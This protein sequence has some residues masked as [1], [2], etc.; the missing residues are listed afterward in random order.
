MTCQYAALTGLVA[1]SIWNLEYRRQR[2][3]NKR[4]MMSRWHCHSIIHSTRKHSANLCAG[5]LNNSQVLL[6]S[7]SI[8]LRSCTQLVPNSHHPQA[9]RIYWYSFRH[10][11]PLSLSDLI[12]VV[13]I[14]VLCSNLLWLVLVSICWY[15]SVFQFGWLPLAWR[16]TPLLVASR[17][18]GVHQQH[19]ARGNRPT[20][21]A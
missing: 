21:M 18:W 20:S 5:M 6:P 4:S 3:P 1:Y 19:R 17:P 10:S 7:L 14:V 2:T 13:P 12:Q 16:P 9:Y 8:N 11:W 15:S